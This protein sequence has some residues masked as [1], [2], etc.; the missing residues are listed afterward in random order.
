LFKGTTGKPPKVLEDLADDFLLAMDALFA[1][2]SCGIVRYLGIDREIAGVWH[3]QPSTEA[4]LSHVLG[5]TAHFGNVT[6]SRLQVR[7]LQV[8]RGRLRSQQVD[9]ATDAVNLLDELRE[10]RDS[11]E[12]IEPL[13]AQLQEFIIRN[14]RDTDDFRAFVLLRA[15]FPLLVSSY[16]L[17]EIQLA[18]I[19]FVADSCRAVR[20][21][22]DEELVRGESVRIA[23]RLGLPPRQLGL[24]LK[25]SSEN[26]EYVAT[27]TDGE[28][29]GPT[30]RD[31]WSVRALF[32]S[33]RREL[34]LELSDAN[35]G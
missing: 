26:Q 17:E 15:A 7:Y 12:P 21:K 32:E 11:P 23:F 18:F 29:D 6:A 3:R 33:L 14:A 2:P 5:I 35:G 27:D 1:A 8:L 19:R 22:R 28:A 4:R 31:E 13:V 25:P 9:D 30:T 16:S 34:E 20:D 24:S 10:N